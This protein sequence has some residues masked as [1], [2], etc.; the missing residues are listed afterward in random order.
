MPLLYFW[1]GDNY[2]HDLDYGVGFHVNQANPLM[3]DIATGESLWAFTRRRV[4]DGRYALAAEL[5]VSSK[6][7]NS[8]SFRYGRYRVW[9]DLRHSRYFSVEGRPDISGLVRNLSVKASAG[10]SADPFRGMPPSVAWK[11]RI[12]FA[13]SPMRRPCRSNLALA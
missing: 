8:Q 12:T 3:Q 10:R 11:R 9:G 7:L 5:V 2:R 6:T 4:S 13:F 1:R